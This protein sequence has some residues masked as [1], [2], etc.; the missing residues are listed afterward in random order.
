[1]ETTK[2]LTQIKRDAIRIFQDAIIVYGEKNR[3]ELFPD[4]TINTATFCANCR[5]K[6]EMWAMLKKLRAEVRATEKAEAEAYEEDF[7]R[8]YGTE[9]QCREIAAAE[10]YAEAGPQAPIYYCPADNDGLS[11]EERS[12]R[13]TTFHEA[14]I[15]DRAKEE[16]SSG[17]L[18]IQAL[19][20]S[21]EAYYVEQ[22]PEA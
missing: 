9:E 3:A 11:F 15:T 4:E 7:E 6:D 14:L 10:A 18:E 2:T 12:M 21:V 19:A 5:V 17:D 22:S 8:R 13:V 20:D 1:M 16:T